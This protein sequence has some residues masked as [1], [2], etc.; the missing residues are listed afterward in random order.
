VKTNRSTKR[1]NRDKIDEV[2]KKLD[3]GHRP[4]CMFPLGAHC[5]CNR[6]C[7]NCWVEFGSLTCLRPAHKTIRK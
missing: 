2:I 5:S 1:V 4:D 6:E 7:E 3:T